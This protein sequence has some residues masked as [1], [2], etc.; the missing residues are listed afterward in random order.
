[1]FDLAD[2]FRVPVTRL[3]ADMPAW[4]FD[5]WVAR[6]ATIPLGSRQEDYRAAV[7]ASAFGGGKDVIDLFPSLKP[8]PDKG[9]RSFRA[10][11]LGRAPGWT[12]GEKGDAS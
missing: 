6:C 5:L 4:E 1:M 11:A 10:W 2:H 12:P 3:M 7:V 9:G 8:P